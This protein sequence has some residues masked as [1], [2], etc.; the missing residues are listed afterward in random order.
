MGCLVFSYVVS[1]NNCAQT[2]A[3]MTFG[4]LATFKGGYIILS[5]QFEENVQKV[6]D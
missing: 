5:V 4:R 3:K 6:G 2:Y 1:A